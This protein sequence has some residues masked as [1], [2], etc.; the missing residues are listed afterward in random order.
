MST[1]D[2]NRLRTKYDSARKNYLRHKLFSR[3]GQKWQVV[4]RRIADKLGFYFHPFVEQPWQEGPN[5]HK[6]SDRRGGAS[7]AG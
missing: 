7:H 2:V 4:C 3:R 5:D 1:E 6:L